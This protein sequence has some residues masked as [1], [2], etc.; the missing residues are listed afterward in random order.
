[1]AKKATSTDM[2]LQFA[3]F[4]GELGSPT[5]ALQELQVGTGLSI[6]GQ[7]IWLIHWVEFWLDLSAIMSETTFV[8][9][10]FWQVI[11][12]RKGLSVIPTLD[13]DGVVAVCMHQ[14][15]VKAAAG[16]AE[17]VANVNV[18][19]IRQQ[20][21]PP[22]PLAAPNLSLYSVCADSV[23]VSVAAPSVARIGFTTAPLDAAAYTEIAET[24]GW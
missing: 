17:N 9:A 23:P 12:T 8:D 13:D 18:Q 11:S 22:V 24:W 19:P 7:L 16:T 14:V 15:N 1:M 2:F 10:E 3:P 20:F 6:R 5:T 21:L 4:A